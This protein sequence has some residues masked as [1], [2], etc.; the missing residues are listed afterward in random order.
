V[1]PAPPGP[2]TQ[3]STQLPVAPPATPALRH[4]VPAGVAADLAAARE[5]TTRL[6][7]LV[8]RTADLAAPSLLPGWTRAHVV[9]HLAGN[10]RSHVRLLDGLPQYEGG[11]V[12][13]AADIAALAADPPAA[14][15]ALHASAADL[16]LAWRRA[17]WNAP[18]Q[19]LDGTSRTASYLAW[20]RWREVEVHAVDLAIVGPEGYLPQDWPEPFLD[21]LLDELLDRP[22]L[23]SIDDVRGN[24]ADLA[25][26]LSGRSRGEGLTGRL[27]D[28]PQWR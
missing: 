25:A 12:G 20:A 17:D 5:A 23:P 2:S 6:L 7:S 8:E 27:P 18:V 3:P 26:W 21:R 9:A 19:V 24:R 1:T 13:R 11:A 10:A 28:L 16:E 22:D 4:G 14:V 15:D